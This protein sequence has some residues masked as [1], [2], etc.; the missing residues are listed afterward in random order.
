MQILLSVPFDK[1]RLRRALT[2]LIRAERKGSGFWGAVITVAG[3]ALWLLRPT[4]SLPYLA[5]AFGMYIMFLQV[6]HLV[7]LSIRRMSPLNTYP[8]QAVLDD[9]GVTVSFAL[10]HTRLLWAAASQIVERPDAWLIIFG[11]LNFMMI[12]KDVMTEEQRAEF[13]EFLRRPNSA[14]VP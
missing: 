13:A 7:A 2:F 8:S 12:P 1:A 6:P 11:P 4:D 5:V 10:G 14:S 9:E 3:A